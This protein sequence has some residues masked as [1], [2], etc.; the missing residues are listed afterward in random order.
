MRIEDQSIIRVIQDY[1]HNRSFTDDS[2]KTH[3][4]TCGV[5]RGSVLGPTLWNVLYDDILRLKTPEG[6]TLVAYADDL[7]IVAT[8]KKE[9]QLILK[10]NHTISLVEQW[11][12]QHL[13][14][15][16]PKKTESVLLIGRKKNT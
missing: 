7:A 6:I 5:P 2:G 9:E 13:L 11:L 10:V 14:E 12:N 8:A 4:M 1:L 15:M 3:Q 16:A